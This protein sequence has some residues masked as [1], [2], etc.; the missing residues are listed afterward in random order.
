MFRS[1][2]DDAW[3]VPE[4]RA[5]QPGDAL[6]RDRGALDEDEQQ[7]LQGQGAAAGEAAVVISAAVIAAVVGQPVH[8]ELGG[9]AHAVL[10]VRSRILPSL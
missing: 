1:L 10:E 2:T 4:A 3:F 7:L 5:S 9:A 6:Y 8:D